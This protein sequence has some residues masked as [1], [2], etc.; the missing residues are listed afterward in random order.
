[1]TLFLS[2][3]NIKLMW[4]IITEQDD[5]LILSEINK[6][7]LLDIFNI[8]LNKYYI[9]EEKE[10]HNLLTLNKG[11]IRLIITEIKLLINNSKTNTNT[12]TNTNTKTKT[13]LVTFEE[14][15]KEKKTRLD[16]EFNRVKEDF[17]NSMLKKVPN[18]PVFEDELIDTP[19]TEM[20]QKLKEMTSQRNYEILQINNN[21]KSDLTKDWLKPMDTSVKSERNQATFTN[22]VYVN[23][24]DNETIKLKYLN[25]SSPTNKYLNQTPEN[26]EKQVSFDTSTI[27]LFKKL[28]KIDIPT[29]KTEN[30]IITLENNIKE[31]NNKI[32]L[33]LTNLNIVNNNNNV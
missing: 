4:D 15:H 10:T 13:E 6:I 2:K 3:E 11:Y 17:A 32:D 12:N 20:E 21:V 23:A 1:M 5:Y 9:K 28:K 14:I 8:N 7:Q 16:N 25:K 18:K 19:I 26:S 24:T 30:R 33:I 27:N 22:N 29:D 31:I